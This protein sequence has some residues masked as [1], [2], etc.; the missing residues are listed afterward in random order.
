[1]PLW[2]RP[3][4]P[5]WS[6][7]KTKGNN[8]VPRS[9]GEH[10]GRR[11]QCKSGGKRSVTRRGSRLSALTARGPR[12]HSLLPPAFP[13]TGLCISQPGPGASRALALSPCCGGHRA[14]L[15]LPL[16]SGPPPPALT[17]GFTPI[18]SIHP[19]ACPDGRFYAPSAPRLAA[20]LP[21]HTPIPC[22]DAPRQLLT[23]VPGGSPGLCSVP[24]SPPARRRASRWRDLPSLPPLPP[25]VLPSAPV[26]GR[27]SPSP[28][29]AP[30]NAPSNR[31]TSGPAGPIRGGNI[32]APT[33]AGCGREVMRSAVAAGTRRSCHHLRHHL[34]PTTS[35]WQRGK[36]REQPGLAG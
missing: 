12:L 15:R 29:N 1:V 3:R 16:R 21:F 4:A 13:G 19:S 36:D 17:G 20:G 23:A 18:L 25:S 6:I 32:W 35:S 27:A 30:R 5:W 7:P 22:P 2:A 34:H 9:G 26:M 24:G 31:A 11:E 10:G 8:S 28:S 33:S 14:P